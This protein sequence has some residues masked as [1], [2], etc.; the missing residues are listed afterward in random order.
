MANKLTLSWRA[1]PPLVRALKKAAA[2]EGVGHATMVRI[3]VKKYLDQQAAQAA[4][5]KT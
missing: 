4:G 3:I 1:D 5:D 2:K